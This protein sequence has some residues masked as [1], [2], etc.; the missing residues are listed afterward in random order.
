LNFPENIVCI[1]EILNKRVIVRGR[2]DEEKSE[3]G[4]EGE[5]GEGWKERRRGRE[6]ERLAYS[7]LIFTQDRLECSN[8]KIINLKNHFKILLSSLFFSLYIPL[9]L[10]LPPLPLPFPPSTWKNCSGVPVNQSKLLNSV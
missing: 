3:R 2:G 4:M 8:S 1:H 10:S 6:R 5:K 7:K 9:P